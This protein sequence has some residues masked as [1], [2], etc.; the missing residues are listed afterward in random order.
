MLVLK[1]AS[2]LK[3]GNDLYEIRARKVQYKKTI[4]ILEEAANL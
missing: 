3:M 4:Y 2:F 1:V